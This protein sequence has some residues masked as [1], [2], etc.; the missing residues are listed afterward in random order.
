LKK[1]VVKHYFLSLG[2]GTKMR[3]REKGAQI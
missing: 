1:L 3:A 2:R